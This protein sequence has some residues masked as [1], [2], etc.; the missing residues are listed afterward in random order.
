MIQIQ[1]KLRFSNKQE[2]QLSEWLHYLSG[3]WNYAVRRIGLDAKDKIF[4]SLIDFQNLL[5]NHSKRLGIPSHII[6]GTLR[7]AYMAWDN[8]FKKL[9]KKP[10][11]KG[12]RNRLNSIP[13]PDPIRIYDN[14]VSV[15]GIG[16]IRFHKQFIPDGKIKCGRIVRRASGWYFCLFIDAMPVQIERKEYGK[17]GID[18]GFENL[19][20]TSGGEVVG[21]PREL[22]KF[23]TRLVQVQRGNRKKLMGRLQERIANRRKDR[24]HKLSKRLVSENVFIAFSADNHKR[25]AKKFGKSVLSSGHYQLRKM[26]AYKSR[27]GG[28]QYVEVNSKFSTMTC[29]VCGVR[30]GPTG[31]SGLAVRQ[32]RCRDCGSLH[33]RDVNAARNTLH[34]ALGTSVKKVA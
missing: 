23:A 12:R 2:R 21:H 3:V 16:R 13:F 8:C 30:S 14:K 20:T 18:S 26:L 32:W 15:P 27:T 28:T 9:L 11:L 5:A 29:S 1:I 24:N 17:I 6:Q 7:T 33:D 4:H 34:A 10:R 25:I 19:L 31:L 22:E